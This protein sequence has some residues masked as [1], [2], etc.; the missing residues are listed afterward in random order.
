MNTSVVIIP[1]GEFLKNRFSS[2][3][4]DMNRVT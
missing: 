1:V 4:N 3:D 2:A